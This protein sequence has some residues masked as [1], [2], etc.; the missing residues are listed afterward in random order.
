MSDDERVAAVERNDLAQ[1]IHRFIKGLERANRQAN[2]RES[3]H[4]VAALSFLQAGHYEAGQ[5]AMA[6]AERLAPLPPEAASLLETNNP[7]PV[8]QL[9]AAFQSILTGQA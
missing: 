4:L 7:I 3:H 5:A 2:R 6:D 8:H 9:R 1:R